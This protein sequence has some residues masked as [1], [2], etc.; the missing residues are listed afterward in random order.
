MKATPVLVGL[1][2]VVTAIAIVW[3]IGREPSEDSGMSAAGLPAVEGAD[4][5][6][7]YRIVYKVT[8]P[9]S[10]GTEEHVVHRPFDARIVVRDADRVVT[11]ERWSSIG[12]LVT[13]AQGADAVRID[14]AVAPAAGDVRPERFNDKL[15]EAGKL[16]LHGAPVDV[17]G[18]ICRLATEAGTAATVGEGAAGSGDAQPLAVTVTRCVDAQGLVLEE[19]WDTLGGERVLT[20][21][22][23]ALELGDDVPRIEVP[24][25]A[26]LPDERGNGAVRKVARDQ[27]P[28]FA[29]AFSVP[30]PQ[31][32]TFVGRFA[33]TPARLSRG[34]EVIPAGADVALYTDVWQRGPDLLLFDQGA[35]KGSATPFAAGTRI[36]TVEIGGFGSAELAVDV[37]SAE[38]RIRRPGG[39]F[40]RLSGTLPLDD[41]IRISSTIQ[42][43]EAA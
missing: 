30:D 21:R 4:P 43:Q 26:A 34:R 1:A 24:D 15:V 3:A 8:T 28:P 18:R 25:A 37:R 23:E 33:I 12:V 41:L 42:V 38:I 7:S 9:D 32:F 5:P 11:A 13:R 2:A 36:G 17:G 16:E 20:K 22:A 35:T 40:V 31:G 27:S 10:I 39:G 14:T 29:E 19:R 6:E